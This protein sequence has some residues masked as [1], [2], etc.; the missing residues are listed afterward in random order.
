M[1]VEIIFA[2]G[3][4]HLALHTR[5]DF[6]FD[7]KNAEFALHEGE[8]HFEAARRI[9]L[10]QHSLLLRDLD[11][12]VGSDRIGKRG[13]LL[14]LAQLNAGFGGEALVELGVI[15]EL[16]DHR[17]HQCLDLGAVDLL[18]GDFLD[19]G[20]GVAVGLVQSDQASAANAFDEN[21]NGAV[22]E[23]QKL[24]RGRDDAQIVKGFAVGIIVG[25]IEL[26]D[27]KDLLVGRHGGFERGDRLFAPDEQ[28]DDPL[29]EDNDVAKWQNWED[30]GQIL[31]LHAGKNARRRVRAIWCGLAFESIDPERIRN[32][33]VGCAVGGATMQTGGPQSWPKCVRHPNWPKFPRAKPVPPPGRG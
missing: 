4:F 18:V 28:R 9:E 7:L 6:L 32:E 8:N 11:R 13:R 19:F 23:L 15:V 2:L 22:G 10:H 30:G 26:G 1:F 31:L 33:R 20:G 25:R 27:E 12:Q 5:A 14:D 24:H 3:L 21:A 29:R 17:A 16:I